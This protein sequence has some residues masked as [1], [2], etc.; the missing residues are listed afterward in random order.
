MSR[1]ESLK[2]HCANP[3]VKVARSASQKKA[4]S[5]DKSRREHASK[6]A[7]A[8]GADQDIIEKRKNS[9]AKLPILKC[10]ICGLEAKS[11]AMTR[12]TAKCG[13]VCTVK[14]CNELHYM[15]NYCKHHFKI[16][17]IAT[18]YNITVAKMFKIFDRA[19]G[20]CEICKKELVMHGSKSDSRKNVACVDH[21]HVTGTVRGIL[22]FNC[23]SALG[24]FSDDVDRI[25]TALQYIKRSL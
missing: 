9:F 25:K 24:H 17:Q 21:C 15:K 6:L 5:N 23:N 12:H 13:T 4:W 8:Q 16:S 7:R 18:T 19:N 22:C 2:A 20:K 1:S 3:D 14:L 10:K 11:H